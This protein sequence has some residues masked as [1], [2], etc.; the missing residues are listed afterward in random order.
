MP[1]MEYQIRAR[2]TTALLA[3]VVAASCSSGGGGGGS[4][5]AAT[6]ITGNDS[7]IDKAAVIYPGS[8]GK[9]DESQFMSW[10]AVSGATAYRLQIGSV[11]GDADLYDSGDISVLQVR[12]PGLPA[13]RQLFGTLS[14]KYATGKIGA[15]DFSF[16]ASGSDMPFTQRFE[17]A[18][19]LAADVRGMADEDNEP[20]A[21]TLLESVVQGDQL[22]AA[23][24]VQYSNTMMALIEQMNLEVQTRVANTCLIPNTYDCHTLVELLDEGTHRWVLT[25]PTFGLTP[26][27]ASDNSIATLDDMR[28]AARSQDWNAISYEYLTTSGASFANYYYLD[29]PL[30]FVTTYV[31]GLPSDQPTLS[32]PVDPDTLTKYYVPVGSLAAPGVYGAYALQCPAGVVQIT[33]VVNGTVQTLDCD[34]TLRATHTILATTIVSQDG[35]AVIQPQRFLFPSAAF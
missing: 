10:S 20:H 28:V 6:A 9:F 12:V 26:R 30:L 32:E 27:N 34:P 29:Y 24:C 5:A 25:D 14:T 17:I 8:D 3:L 33:P 13:G 11:Y 4:I 7:S 23:G 1:R 18:R 35:A 15:A 21:G 2:L 19:K 31:S 22:T 16:T